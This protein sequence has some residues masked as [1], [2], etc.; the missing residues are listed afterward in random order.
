MD[1]TRPVAE[2]K[3]KTCLH[4]MVKFAEGED[5][6]WGEKVIF[7]KEV[8]EKGE[9]LCRKVDK[10]IARLRRLSKKENEN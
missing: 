3:S 8:A 5:A 1:V 10:E 4:S 7:A 6:D 9:K 2:G